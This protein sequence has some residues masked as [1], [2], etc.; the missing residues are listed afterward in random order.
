MILKKG[1]SGKLNHNNNKKIEIMAAISTAV[2]LGRVSAIAGYAVDATLEGIKAGNLPQRVVIL[3]EAN[4]AN[5]SGLPGSLKFTN[6]SEVGAVGGYGSPAYHAARILRPLS[7]DRL[8]GIPT[9]WI[10]VAESAGATAT[11]ITKSITGTA[12]KNATH[13][14]IVSGRD[15]LDGD[16]YSYAIEK[17]DKNTEVSQK[18]A[19]AINNVQGAPAIGTVDTAQAVFT[20]K[21]SGISSEEFNVT[22]DVGDDAAG[23][24]YGEVSKVDGAGLPG[25]SDAL[26]EI[27]D[28]WTTIIVNA[29][30]ADSTILD[31]I[32]AFIGDANSKS[33]R[34]LA[35]DFK[36]CISFF[37]DNTVDTLAEATAITDARKNEMANVLC[38]APNSLGFSFEAA[39]NVAIEQ[40]LLSQNEP[41]SDLLGVLY[42]DMPTADSAGDF[43]DPAKRDQIVKVGSSTVKINS[44]SYEIVD[45]VTTS[46]PDNEP[47]TAVLFRW[48]RDLMLDWNVAYKYQLLE[49]IYVKGKTILEDGQT[50][51]APN[52]I[53][54]SR[55]KSIISSQLAPQL[56]DEGLSADADYMKESIQVQIG[57][58]N[59]NRFETSFKMKR[60]GIARVQ[61]TTNKT[62]FNF[63]G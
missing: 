12:T 18:M 21:W 19:D 59:P 30:S 22:I 17:G 63:G 34:Y 52:T 39:A 55:W 10:P 24:T 51:S 28:Q 32:E 6:P 38:P 41:H 56:V 1:I 61:S 44:E 26:A 49:E 25:I 60:T 16:S 4:T 48:V 35:V 62:Q 14:L 7:G 2:D 37:G 45:L 29:V 13:K 58:S 42:P 50:S 9:I 47:Q 8:G 23:L 20:T 43:S 27:G 57:E 11:V 53:S 15:G 31:A 46:H 54:P 33:G 40:A 36:P 5:Q 3:A